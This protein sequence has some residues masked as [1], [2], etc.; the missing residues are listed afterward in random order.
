MRINTV[1]FDMD[2]TL[3]NTLDDIADSTNAVLEKH[4]YP[5]WPVS[6]IRH[7]VGSGAEV[8][9]SRALPN[10]MDE[11][12][13]KDLLSEYK[14]YYEEH[15]NIKT[16]PYTHM[17]DLLREL[18]ADGY[19]MAIVSNKPMGAVQE[20]TRAYFGDYFNVAIGVT[21]ALRRK[22]YPDQCLKAM[23]ELGS[24]MEE[25]IYVGDSEID[26]QTAVNTGL[27]CISCLW[28]FRTRQELIDAGAGNN[29]FVED[30]LDILKVLK[31]LNA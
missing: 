3:L 13:F 11:P 30:P 16:G 19:K 24:T 12:G 18:K 31:D 5:T 23:E 17:M 1:I 22:P 9:M 20:L 10:G 7:F 8:L 14:A 28:G 26:H 2:G 4:G 15:C 21:E 27:K 6:D 25:S 29:I